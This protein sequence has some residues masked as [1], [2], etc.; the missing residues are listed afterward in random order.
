MGIMAPPS[1]LILEIVQMAYFSGKKGF[2]SLLAGNA[3]LESIVLS[4]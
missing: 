2:V 4:E 3:D 1:G